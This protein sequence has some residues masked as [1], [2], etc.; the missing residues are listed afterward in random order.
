MISLA[1]IVASAHLYAAAVQPAAEGVWNA[2]YKTSEGRVHAFTLTLK[3]DG[4]ALAGT[5][6]SPRGSVNITEGTQDGNKI[7]LKVTR[8]ANY[9]S[10]DVI[11]EGVV[12][13]DVMKLTMR[14]GVREPV[15]VTARRGAPTPPAPVT[16]TSS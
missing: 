16:G 5:I 2:E 1:L 9:D 14:V 7:W 3:A 13:G 10:I 15:E 12:D 6:S 11:Y 4:R 8:R